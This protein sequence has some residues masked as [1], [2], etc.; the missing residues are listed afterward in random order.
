MMPDSSS[1]VDLARLRWRCRRG[2]LEL[3]LILQSVLDNRFAGLTA[4]ERE[5]FL[6]MLELSDNQLLDYLQ[7]RA[8]PEQ[9]ELKRL[10]KKIL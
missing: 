1:P 7:G 6:E 5:T 10:L 3:D 2:L 8:K 9:T 4:P